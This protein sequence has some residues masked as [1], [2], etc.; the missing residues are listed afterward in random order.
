MRGTTWRPA[1][2]PPRAQSQS[3]CSAARP[4]SISSRVANIARCIAITPSRPVRCAVAS[5]LPAKNEEHHPPLRPDA[6][7]PATSASQTTTRSVGSARFNA[8]AVHKPG[9]ARRRRSRRRRRGHR[10]AA[11]AAFVPLRAASRATSWFPRSRSLP[12]SM[13]PR[14]IR[15]ET[16][17]HVA[18]VTIDNPPVN[19]LPVGGWFALADA[20]R[21]AGHDP[22]VRVVVLHAEGQGLPSGRRHQGARRRPDARVAHR[23]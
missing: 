20:V 14:M 23:A 21:D 6:P 15:S 19:A 5:R 17:D 1:M 8:Y 10:A 16:R 12:G 18:I 9:V 11:G 2:V 4:D 13:L 3:I 7:K 22:D